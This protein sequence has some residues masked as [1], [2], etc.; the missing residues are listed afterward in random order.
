M[1]ELV[2]S[3]V[4]LWLAKQINDD[5]PQGTEVMA[6]RLSKIAGAIPFGDLVAAQAILDSAT[7]SKGLQI[8]LIEALMD[9]QPRTDGLTVG[10]K[11]AIDL[12]GVGVLNAEVRTKRFAV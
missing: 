6:T 12:P 11:V 7:H 5:C 10:T 3:E 4:A 1:P 8:S 9:M 2:A